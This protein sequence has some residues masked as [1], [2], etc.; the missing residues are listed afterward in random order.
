MHPSVRH[1]FLAYTIDLLVAYGCVL[2]MVLAA[3]LV[4]VEVFN[5]P[6]PAEKRILNS[7]WQAI[8]PMAV[9]VFFCYLFYSN[10]FLQGR[11]LGC[12]CFDFSIS[13]STGGGKV[14]ELTFA[15]SLLRSLAQVLCL[16]SLKVF[17]YLPFLLFPL[18]RKDQR[19]VAD[20]LSQSQSFLD[21]LPRHRQQQQSVEVVEEELKRAA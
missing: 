4:V 9:W 11:S 2:A 20:I 10:Y 7:Y 21:A 15:E 12:I 16:I 1:R 18:L 17:V 3:N 13:T 14:R 19:G 8:H 5:L 6:G